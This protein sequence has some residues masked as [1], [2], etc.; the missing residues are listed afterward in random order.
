MII[1]HLGGAVGWQIPE[2]P[3][4]IGGGQALEFEAVKTLVRPWLSADVDKR[5]RMQ[6][7][8]SD[9]LYDLVRGNIKRGRAF[10]LDEVLATRRADCFG[11][12]RLFS[13]L[14]AEFGLEIGVVEVLIDNAGRYVPHHVALLNLADGRHRF[15]DAWYGSRDINHRR[16]GA[17]VNGKPGDIDADALSGISELR[18]LPETCLEAIALYIRGNGCLAGNELD[19]A[20]EYYSAAIRLYPGNS[21]AYYNRA[22]AHE[23]KGEVDAAQAD[24][25]RALHDESSLIRVLATTRGLE[26]LISLDEKGI[27]EREQAIYLRYKGYQTGT[28]AGY[29]EIGHEYGVSP[30][31]VKKIIDGVERLCTG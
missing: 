29:E 27:G 18:G 3:G 10:E 22:I 4:E 25:A 20:I 19:K 26:E 23:R 12:A 21:R 11:Y 5:S 9:W 1:M 30:E 7:A 16:M 17:R 28:G 6:V 24:Y 2:L 15:L 8:V 13:A 31:D 14:G